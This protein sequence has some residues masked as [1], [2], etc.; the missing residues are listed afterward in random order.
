MKHKTYYA[1][2]RE[3]EEFHYPAPASKQGEGRR[4][5]ELFGI[6]NDDG[7]R[8][9]QN[10]THFN[11][12]VDNEDRENELIAS[13]DADKEENYIPADEEDTTIKEIPAYY[14]RA[15]KAPRSAMPAV[16][17][18]LFAVMSSDDPR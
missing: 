4:N 10:Q 8:E 11:D 14:V 7:E 15:R 18:D 5:N 17:D 12:I 2:P 6:L 3:R 1:D 13:I 16:E 9:E